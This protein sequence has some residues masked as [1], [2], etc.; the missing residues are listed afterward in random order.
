MSIFQRLFGSSSA[1]QRE[2]LEATHPVFRLKAGMGKEAVTGLL[3]GDY[4]SMT[5]GQFVESR[6]ASPGVVDIIDPS[7]LEQEY[8]LYSDQGHYIEIVFR[9]GSLVSAEVKTKNADRSET[10]L[11]RIDQEGLA[12]AEPYR[13]ALGANRL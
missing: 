4:L 13:A 8:W 7:V 3:G 1:A 5:G 11:A 10:L 2:P 12:A 6:Q 9:S